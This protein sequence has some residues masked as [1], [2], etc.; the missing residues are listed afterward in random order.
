MHAVNSSDGFSRGVII[1]IR[2]ERRSTEISEGRT[3]SSEK[4]VFA[5]IQSA[6]KNFPD[7]WIE[8]FEHCFQSGRFQLLT[9]LVE[10]WR[11]RHGRSIHPLKVQ[12][13]DFGRGS[14]LWNKKGNKFFRR[15][16]SVSMKIRLRVNGIIRNSG[17]NMLY[18]WCIQIFN[19]CMNHQNVPPWI[20]DILLIQG[21]TF[22][23]ICQPFLQKNG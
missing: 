10:G 2:W 6:G 17:T 5:V 18:S 1:V 11:S 19:F 20:S 8:M 16:F 23:Y 4:M 7:R 9:L 22:W 14:P 15:N 21:G 13:F 3:I 12:H